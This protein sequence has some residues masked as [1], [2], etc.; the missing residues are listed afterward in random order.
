M[1]L[2]HQVSTGYGQPLLQSSFLFQL[3]KPVSLFQASSVL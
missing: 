1:D 2:C 3:A